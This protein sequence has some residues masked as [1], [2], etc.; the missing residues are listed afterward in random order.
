ML[1]P[2]FQLQSY[3]PETGVL[4]KH[5]GPLSSPQLLLNWGG[6]LA[7]KEPEKIVFLTERPLQEWDGV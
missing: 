5:A 2:A 1:N 3:D 7:N 6:R 4:K